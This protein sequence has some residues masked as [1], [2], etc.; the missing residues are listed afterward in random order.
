MRVKK[1]NDLPEVKGAAMS[2]GSKGQ[3]FWA[4]CKFESQ[5]KEE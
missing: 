3:G 5:K 2:D 1:G 4:L